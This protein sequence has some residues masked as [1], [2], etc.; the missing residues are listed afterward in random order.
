[1][2]SGAPAAIQIRRLRVPRVSRD[3]VL[4]VSVSR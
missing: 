3:G 4:A 1:L 2:S